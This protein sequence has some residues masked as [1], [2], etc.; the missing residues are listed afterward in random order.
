MNILKTHQVDIARYTILPAVAAKVWACIR[1]FNSMP[2]WHAG[3]V[4]SQIEGGPADRI[5]CLRVLDFG[6]GG[7]WTHQLTGLSDRDMILEYQIIDGPKT[8][9]TFIQH[10][11]ARMQVIPMEHASNRSSNLLWEASFR[12]DNPEV[13]QARA[14]DVFEAG[15]KG[16]RRHLLLS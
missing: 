12:S 15:F 5:G 2:Q 1:D 7:L 4:G 8:S 16:L 13:A 14:G 3:V 6:A 9:A 10:Y 11:R